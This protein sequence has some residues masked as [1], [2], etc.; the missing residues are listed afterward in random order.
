MSAISS[1]AANKQDNRFEYNG[2]EKQEREFSDG[3]GLDWYDYGARMYDAQIG[4]WQRIDPKVEK[5]ESISPYAYTFNNPIRFIDIKGEDPGDVVVIFAGADLFSN[6]GL[7]STGTIAQGV[8]NGHTNSRG[9]SVMNFPSQYVNTRY[10]ATP[11]GSATVLEPVNLDDATEA[12]YNYIK[13]NRTEDGQVIV[14]GYSWGGVLANHL[15]KRLEKDKI[16]V[17]FLI[18]IDAA[19]GPGSD[20]VDRTVGTNVEDNLNIY[21]KNKSA[22]GSRGDKNT[23]N[24]SSGKGIR[25]EISVSFTDEKGKKQKT[26]HSNIDEATLFK[27]IYEVIKKLDRK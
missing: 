16:K 19:D 6:G 2:K 1:R 23:R 26:V 15:A 12:A 20:K 22:I 9:G 25:N 10:T 11:V 5:Y 7:G 27:V 17:S 8:K 21:Q 14:Y 24:D 13:E 3:S 4:R 18:T